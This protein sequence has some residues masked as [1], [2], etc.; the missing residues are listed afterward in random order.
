MNSEKLGLAVIGSGRMGLRRSGLATAHPCVG[1]VAVTDLDID[2]ARALAE[3]NRLSSYSD[4]NLEVIKRP[5]VDAVIVSTSERQH[6]E[7]AVQAIELGKPV[8]IEKP[9]AMTLEDADRII[10]ASKANDVEVRVAYSRRFKRS[11][12]LAKEQ[13]A[14]GKLGQIVGA[15]TRAYNSRA[16]H[17]QVFQRSPG[18]SGVMAGLTYYVDIVGWFMAGNPPV[19]VIARGQKGAFRAAGQDVDD[20]TWAIVTYADGAVVSFGV[21]YALPANFPIFGPAE[22]M[23]VLGTEGV[24]LIDHD[25]KDHILYTDHG[26]GHNYVPD[27]SLNL[28]FMGSSSSGDWAQGEFWGPVEAETRTWIDHLVTGRNCNLATVAEAR[29]TLAVTLAIEEAVRTGGS[30]HLPA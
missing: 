26:L 29:T 23:E 6:A 19:E 30:V 20:M 5:E 8:L 16:Q 12:F 18:A 15:S 21:N 1:Y 11:Y 24:I 4:D 10:A 7:P 27:H 28:A 14:A 25:H 3:K 22:R 9:L 13:I 17:M 2:R